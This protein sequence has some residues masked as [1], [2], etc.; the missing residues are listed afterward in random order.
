MCCVV[1]TE[2][3]LG[4]TIPDLFLAVMKM[5]LFLVVG[6]LKIILIFEMTQSNDFVKLLAQPWMQLIWFHAWS[7]MW[8]AYPSSPYVNPP[9]LLVSFLSC[10]N[11]ATRCRCVQ[12]LREI[13]SE[14]WGKDNSKHLSLCTA[15]LR[16]ITHKAVRVFHKHWNCILFIELVS[17]R[18]LCFYQEVLL[19]ICNNTNLKTS[20]STSQ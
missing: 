19:L 1:I 13:A 15:V 18:R 5:S 4:L 8:P 16:Y 9:A 20:K 17:K 7:C 6:R 11:F 12:W 14:D 10:L 3:V 2:T